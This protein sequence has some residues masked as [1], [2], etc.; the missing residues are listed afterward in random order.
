MENVPL[1]ATEL[2]DLLGI[3]GRKVIE[4]NGTAANFSITF[5]LRWVIF[6]RLRL[7]KHVDSRNP[8]KVLLLPREGALWSLWR[9][10]IANSH[11]DEVAYGADNDDA[12]EY[13]YPKS[14]PN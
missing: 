2:C 14:Q 6:S 9:I 8:R 7:N 13:D 5:S 12:Q 4:A 3:L 1:V 11:L 10:S